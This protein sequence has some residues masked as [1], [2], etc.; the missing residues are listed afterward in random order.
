MKQVV[1]LFWLALRFVVCCLHPSCFLIIWGHH[2][3]F[4]WTASQCFPILYEPSTLLNTQIIKLCIM[5]IHVIG[6]L[7]DTDIE[8]TSATNGT[9][10]SSVIHG[11]VVL[12]GTIDNSSSTESAWVRCDDCFKWRRIPAS[13]VESI[14]ESSRWYVLFHIAYELVSMK[15]TDE[16]LFLRV[17]LIEKIIF[18]VLLDYKSRWM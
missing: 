6:A 13:V 12:H 9:I 3:V 7:L 10:S 14:D 8:K 11:E 18:T 16:L 2:F 5:W 17:L 1:R 15:F 4:A